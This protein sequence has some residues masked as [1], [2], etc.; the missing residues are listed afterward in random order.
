MVQLSFYIMALSDA[1]TFE[2]IGIF[3]NEFQTREAAVVFFAK[4]SSIGVRK[5]VLA[6]YH[7]ILTNYGDSVL[8]C[9][10]R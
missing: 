3:E 10:L 9:K 1:F 6:I 7:F 5:V 4:H 8:F 2:D